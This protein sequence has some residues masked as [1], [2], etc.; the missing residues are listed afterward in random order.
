MVSSVLFVGGGTASLFCAYE[1]VEKGYK[2]KI[3]II[4]EGK[5]LK[6]RYCPKNK[7]GKCE[8]CKICAVTRGLSGAGFANKIK[9]LKEIQRNSKKNVLN[10]M[11]N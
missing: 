5:D 8:H 7:T 2:G 10:Y 4:E 9:K 6:N 11:K 3:T 1:L